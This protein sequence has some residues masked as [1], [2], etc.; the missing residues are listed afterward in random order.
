M[1]SPYHYAGQRMARMLTRP[2]VQR[3]LD[4]ALS[5]LG[6]GD[7]DLQIE[8]VPVEVGSKLSGLALEE[9]EIRK[10]LGTIILAIRHKNGNLDFNPGPDDLISSGDFLIAMGDP[11]KLKELEILAGVT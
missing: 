11:L 4:L 3:F 10:R 2:H 1:I 5:S 8:E 6:D 7:L 9:A